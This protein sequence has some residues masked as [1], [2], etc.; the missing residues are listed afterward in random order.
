M[1]P[2]ARFARARLARAGTRRRHADRQRRRAQSRVGRAPERADRGRVPL[3]AGRRISDERSR[4]DRAGAVRSGPRVAIR[5]RGSRRDGRGPLPRQLQSR[6]PRRGACR[7]TRKSNVESRKSKVK[8][9]KAKSGPWPLVAGVIAMLV[10]SLRGQQPQTQTP[11]DPAFRF[12]SGVE[13]INVTASVSDASGRF[14]PGLRQE[15]FLVHE[16]DQPV[17]VTH[18]TRGARAGQSHRARH[19]RQHGG[20]EDSGGAGRAR[21]LPSSC[22]TSRIRFFYRFSNRPVLLQEWTRDRQLLSRRALG[23]ITP[24]GGTAMYDTIAEAIPPAQRGENQKKALLVISTATTRPARLTS[25]IS[26]SRFARAST[27][28]AIGIDG[29]VLTQPAQPCV[30]IPMLPRRRT[31]QNLPAADRWRRRKRQPGGWRRGNDDAVNVT[32]LP[33]RQRRLHRDHPRSVTI[34]TTATVSIA[35]ELSKQYHSGLSVRRKATGRWHTIRV[36]L[37]N[38]SAYRVRARR[39]YMAS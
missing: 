38:K 25:A 32:A 35:D 1:W 2:E 11:A 15:D 12:K 6:R 19:E 37:R 36:E 4:R 17:E 31:T 21:S 5:G 20:A 27:V 3:H 39:G 30:P 33:G 9:P 26:R 22:S 29:D 7:Q 23:R 24:N 10:V 28:Y 13:L 34:L 8:S 18:P 14:V 16:D